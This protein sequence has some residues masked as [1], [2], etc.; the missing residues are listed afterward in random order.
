MA[1]DC[2]SILAREL[3]SGERLLWSGKPKAG[4]QIKATDVIEV[5]PFV[6]ILVVAIYFLVDPTF[7]FGLVFG[8]TFLIW[9]LYHVLG[10]FVVDAIWRAKGCYALTNERIIIVLG[11]R[12][13]TARSFDLRTISNIS[14]IESHDGTGTIEFGAGAPPLPYARFY[15]RIWSTPA[16]ESIENGKDVYELIRKAQRDAS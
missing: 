7:L 6:L 1:D 12:K 8:I 14:L 16:L 15:P 3:G 2:D 5:V 10:R 9:G 13:R 11:F 4:I